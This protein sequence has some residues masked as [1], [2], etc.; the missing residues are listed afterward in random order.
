MD[1]ICC[2]SYLDRS[3]KVACRIAD[4]GL[5]LLH[6]LTFITTN[7]KTLTFLLP[8]CPSIMSVGRRASREEA[9]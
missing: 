4:S 1:S 6:K 2:T 8:N 7:A 3:A 5:N 9:T